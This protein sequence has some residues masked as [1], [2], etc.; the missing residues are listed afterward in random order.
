M[1]F[2]ALV[3]KLFLSPPSILSDFVSGVSSMFEDTSCNYSEL[4]NAAEALFGRS[5]ACPIM[6]GEL[7]ANLGRI[8]GQFG[9]N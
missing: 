5:L 6:V 4:S 2:I 7:R 8:K 9:A 1:M 3:S